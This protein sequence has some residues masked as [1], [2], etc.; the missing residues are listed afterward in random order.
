MWSILP[1]NTPLSDYRAGAK[2]RGLI[3]GNTDEVVDTLGQLGETR[4]FLNS[5]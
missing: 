2:A 5:G 3:V 4:A 1:A